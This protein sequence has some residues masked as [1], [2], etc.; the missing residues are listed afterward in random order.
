MSMNGNEVHTCVE[1]GDEDP[2]DQMVQRGEE[3]FC[4]ECDPGKEQELDPVDYYE[5]ARNG[6]DR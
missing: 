3:W 4:K 2:E 5:F 1:C 6:G